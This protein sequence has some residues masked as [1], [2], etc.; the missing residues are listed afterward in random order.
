[1]QTNL[2]CIWKRT[3][4]YS[5][6]QIRTYKNVYKYFYIIRFPHYRSWQ[7]N[8]NIVTEQIYMFEITRILELSKLTFL[9]LDIASAPGA[10][11][12]PLTQRHS[13]LSST[14]YYRACAHT[15]HSIQSLSP[16]P[17]PATAALDLLENSRVRVWSSRM[18]LC[19]VFCITTPIARVSVR[20]CDRFV[21]IYY[22]ITNVYTYILCTV[23]QLML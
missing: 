20:R 2:G 1:M 16:H 18:L 14:Q 11:L 4:N 12:Q 17:S 22:S 5:V 13:L 9:R 15:L 8:V 7:C 19:V 21:N 23:I 6:A 10:R 3:F